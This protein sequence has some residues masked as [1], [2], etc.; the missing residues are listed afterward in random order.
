MSVT[1]KYGKYTISH[2]GCVISSCIL[3]HEI[4][5]HDFSVS[6]PFLSLPSLEVVDGLLHTFLVVANHVLVHVGI[7]GA[8][9][10][11]CAAVGHCAKAQRRVLLR[12]LLELHK[13]R[14]WAEIKVIEGNSEVKERERKSRDRS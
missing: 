9:V 14:R 5:R 12:R 10:L 6:S 3:L 2:E 8:N 7:V 1:C 11:L 13:K 4:K